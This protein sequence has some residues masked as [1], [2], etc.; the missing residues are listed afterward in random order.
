MLRRGIQRSSNIIA[1]NSIKSKPTTISSPS[2]LLRTM[3]S[4]VTSS[5]FKP[6]PTAMVESHG[7]YRAESY[8]EDHIGGKLYEK[9]H[10]LPRLPIPA[11]SETISRLLP[12]ALPL[13]KSDEEKESYIKACEVF[14]GQAG[15]LQKRLIERKE[16]EMKDS[17]WLQLWWNTLGYLQVSFVVRCA[18]RLWFEFINFCSHLM[19]NATTWNTHHNQLHNVLT[20]SSFVS[21][22]SIW[23]TQL[24]GTRSSSCQR[25]LLLPLLRWWIS[26]SNPTIR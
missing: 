10:T 3:S 11:I 16:G 1:A 17:S 21:N 9:Q 2:L 8:L 7:D 14:E 20:D 25:I 22:L 23:T 6:W 13:A 18:N 19:S 15:E 5:N 24:K 26:S 4:S 12:T